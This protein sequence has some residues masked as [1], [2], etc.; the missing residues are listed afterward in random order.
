ELRARAGRGTAAHADPQCRRPGRGRGGAAGAVRDRRPRPAGAG[1]GGRA[2]RPGRRR[3]AA[4]RLHRDHPPEAGAP[5]MSDAFWVSYVLLWILVAGLLG[6][7]LLLYRQFGMSYLAPH[8][9]VS[10]QGLDVGSR[11]PAVALEEL[12]GTE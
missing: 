1:D 12:D 7:V 9:Q 3:T 8:T 2:A 4:D 11:A 10:M 5:G 6:L